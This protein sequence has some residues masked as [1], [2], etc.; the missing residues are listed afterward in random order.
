MVHSTGALAVVRT[1]HN[2]LYIHGNGTYES[3]VQHKSG[4]TNHWYSGIRTSAGLATT[5]GYHIY[6][7]A[8]GND[9]FGLQTNGYAY[10]AAQ[11]TLWGA[12][13]D[14]AGSGLDA[15]LLDG[16]ELHTG[17][18]NEANKVVRTNASGYIDASY[19]NTTSGAYTSEVPNRFYA[20]DDAYL[21]Y[22][23]RTWMQN[24]LGL[25]GKTSFVPRSASNTS[26]YYRTGS[27]GWASLNFNDMFNRGSCFI[28]LWSHTNGPTT[29]HSNG[30]Q[31]LHYSASNTYHHGMQ[32]VMQSGNPS[33]TYLRGWWANG[34][35]GYAW[36]K[37]W[38]DGNDGSGS[39]LDADLLRWKSSFGFLRCIC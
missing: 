16:L 26:E 11:G 37:I 7:A 2:Y 30:F 14:G 29:G 3:M 12:S 4:H 21:R 31:S 8:Y 36:Q 25:S 6:S 15:D 22:Y 18:N 13:N 27:Q 17:R 34:G 35:T 23:T 19:I 1:A 28:D 38:T 10:S 32:M 5:T 39:G 9:V 20:S 33:H 24:H